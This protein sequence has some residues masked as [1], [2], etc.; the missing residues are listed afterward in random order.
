MDGELRSADIGR[1]SAFVPYRIRQVK[2]VLNDTSIEV[3]ETWNHPLDAIPNAA[4]V[5]DKLL[6]RHRGPVA[7]DSP[8]ETRDDRGLTQQT[9]ASR[10]EMAARRTDYPHTV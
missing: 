7:E 8:G 2:Y 3:F 9:L 10:F 1:K 6:P 4:V 5:G